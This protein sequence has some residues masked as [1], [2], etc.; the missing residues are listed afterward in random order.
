MSIEPGNTAPQFCLP[1]QQNAPICLNH[2]LGKWIILYFYPKD[3]TP[4]CTMEACA[5]RDTHEQLQANDAVIL[6]VSSDSAVRH[7][8][9]SEKFNLPFELLADTEKMVMTQYEAWGEKKNFGRIYQGVKRMTYIIDPEGNVAK[10]FKT[11]KPATHAKQ[12]LEALE[13]LQTK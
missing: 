3:Y 2:Y 11:V 6:G 7:A 9:F 12:V 5:F 1:N 4:G 10:V 13:T 8:S